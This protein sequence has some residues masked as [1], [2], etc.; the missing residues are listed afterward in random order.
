ME[1]ALLAHPGE[2]EKVPV[3]VEPVTVQLPKLA[4]NA[5]VLLL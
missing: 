1:A 5:P 4:L 2:A 3:M